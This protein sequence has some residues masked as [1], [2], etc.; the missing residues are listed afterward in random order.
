MTICYFSATGN[1]LSA[2]RHIAEKTHA[3]LASIP[4]IIDQDKIQID[5]DRIGIVFPAYIPALSGVPLIIERFINKLEAISSKYLFAVCTCGGYQL[6]NAF[7]ALRTLK[8]MIRSAGGK[9]SAGYTVRLPMN[10]LDYD[11]IPVPINKDTETIIARSRGRLAAITK[12][13]IKRQPDPFRAWKSFFNLLLAPMYRM[14][15]KPVMALF[16]IYAQVPADS[17]LTY[18]E[19]VPLTDKSITVGDR[20]NGCATCARVCPVGNI[21]MISDRPVWQHHCE[22]CFACDE[23]CPQKAVQHWS[24]AAGVKYRHPG[25]KVKDFMMNKK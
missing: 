21:K 18:R 1:C 24:R 22:M 14:M 3:A 10:N 9:L 7:P 20:C 12:Q 6:V 16:R 13:I 4:A 11:H 25:V 5:D 23:W 19:L 15:R 8:R 17:P 2:A